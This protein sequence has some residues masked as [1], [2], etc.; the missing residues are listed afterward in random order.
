MTCLHY[1]KYKRANNPKQKYII[2]SLPTKMLKQVDVR[3]GKEKK[4]KRKS[5]K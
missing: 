2:I 5:M 4:K 1:A 3:K